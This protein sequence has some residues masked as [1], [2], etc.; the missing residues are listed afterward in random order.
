VA[1]IAYGFTISEDVS[2]G[3][4]QERFSRISGVSA[5]LDRAI[6]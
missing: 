4:S 1:H 6:Q 3:L 2:F 5:R